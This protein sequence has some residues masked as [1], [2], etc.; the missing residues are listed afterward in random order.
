VDQVELPVDEQQVGGHEGLEPLDGGRA[1]SQRRRTAQ[2]RRRQ[3][4]LALAEQG[5][6][7]P[8]R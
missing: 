1:R 7:R 2:Q 6:G 4:A 8:C 5:E 3:L